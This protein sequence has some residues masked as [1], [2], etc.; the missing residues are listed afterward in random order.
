MDKVYKVCT[1]L[2]QTIFLLKLIVKTF[3]VYVNRQNVFVYYFQNICI[4]YKRG[5]Y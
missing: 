4:K 3:V 1:L 2:L 5:K